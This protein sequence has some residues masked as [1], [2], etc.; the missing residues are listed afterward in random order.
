MSEIPAFYSSSQIPANKFTEFI[1]ELNDKGFER[2]QSEIFPG[3]VSEIW[4]D[5]HGN[6]AFIA[7]D[8]EGIDVDIEDPASPLLRDNL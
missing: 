4:R 2:V 1:E 8:S 6:E 3:Y 7:R 5:F